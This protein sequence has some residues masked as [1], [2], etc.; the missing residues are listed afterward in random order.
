M[1]TVTRQC[2]GVLHGDLVLPFDDDLFAGCTVA[3]VLTDPARFE[4]ATLADPLE[5]IDYGRFVAKIMRRVDG[6]PWIHS[7]AHG[8][9]VYELKH[10]IRAVRAAIE[11]AAN[12]AVV[13]IFMK[14]AIAADLNEEEIEGLCNLVANRSGVHKRT[15][16]AMLKAAQRDHTTSHERQQRERRLAERQDPRPMINAPSDDA[17]WLPQMEALNDVIGKSIAAHPAVR[18]IDG[19]AALTMRIAVPA[20]HAFSPLGANSEEKTND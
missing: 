8:R 5:G 1:Q 2:D 19:V 9:M 12:D 4:G 18:D 3:D 17:P 16:T 20:T 10:N 7:F 6:S 13:G 14:L 15:I 11:R